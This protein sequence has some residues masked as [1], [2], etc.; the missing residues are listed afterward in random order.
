M[1]QVKRGSFGGSEALSG[2]VDYD[3]EINKTEVTL[4]LWEFRA[5]ANVE[6]RHIRQS[7][8]GHTWRLTKI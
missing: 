7:S 2:S 8:G 5:S 1:Q 4:P 3:F 6:V